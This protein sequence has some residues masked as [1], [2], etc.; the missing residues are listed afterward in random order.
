MS[1][2]KGFE[3]KINN[4]DYLVRC[5]F[6]TCTNAQN[7]D[8]DVSLKTTMNIQ[9]FKNKQLVKVRKDSYLAEKISDFIRNCVNGQ[10]TCYWDCDGINRHLRKEEPKVVKKL[11]EVT[12][13]EMQEYCKKKDYCVNCVFGKCDVCNGGL[14]DCADLEK[15]VEL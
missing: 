14:I 9:V 4:E 15:E 2:I 5:S 13:E 11:K 8:K 3:I 7:N 10:D 1:C 12:L 6:S